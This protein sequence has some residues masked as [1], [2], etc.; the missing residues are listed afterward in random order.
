MTPTLARTYR[1]TSILAAGALIS[2][3]EMVDPD[4]RNYSGNGLDT[5]TAATNSTARAMP[6]SRGI[7]TY[8][9]YQAVIARSGDTVATVAAR[10]GVD[11]A[12][13]ARFNG[14]SPTA[15]LR[16]GEVL[17][18]PF[19]V[20]TDITSI[21]SGAIDRAGSGGVTTTSLGQAQPGSD[22]PFTAPPGGEPIRHQVQRG[23]TVYTISRLYNVPVRTI[24]EWNGLGADLNVREGQQ[25][26]IPHAAGDSTGTADPVT[27]PGTQSPTPTPPSA[28]TPL[29]VETVPAAT[30]T[31]PP[32]TPDLGTTAATSEKPLIM[33]VQGSIVNAYDPGKNEGIDIAAAAGTEV[34][35]AAAGTVAAVTTDTN[36]VAIVVIKHAGNLLTVYTFIDNLKVAKNDSVS[37]GQVIGLVREGS[38][39]ILH[40]EVRDGLSSVDPTLYLP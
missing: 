5:S 34:H 28:A 7:I 25:L 13:L 36:G 17:V 38:P 27:L 15:S 18:L 8:P 19:R 32:A 37:Q 33:P 12:E 21:A 11:P 29:P 1:L 3:C 23:E 10:I 2:A 35:A 14:V 40:F 6:D 20:S 16:E 24:A 22:Q 4:L 31:A 26:L 9:N 30:E 39:S